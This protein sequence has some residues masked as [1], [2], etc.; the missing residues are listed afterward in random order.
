MDQGWTHK[1]REPELGHRKAQVYCLTRTFSRCINL[2]FAY[3]SSLTFRHT[4][5]PSQQS[6]SSLTKVP[7]YVAMT[8]I[9]AISSPYF[10]DGFLPSQPAVLRL[11]SQWD[12][13]ED[14]LS[15]AA[16]R[17]GFDLSPSPGGIPELEKWRDSVRKACIHPHHIH[18]ISLIYLLI[19]SMAIPC[20]TFSD[21][22]L[23]H[24]RAF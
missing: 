21:A 17:I 4:F 11:P 19:I 23:T 5:E 12:A 14:I 16:S 2:L 10:E 13:W 20:L 3:R 24:T 6:F 15:D 1:I 18:H 8:R 7:F 22:S 9:Q